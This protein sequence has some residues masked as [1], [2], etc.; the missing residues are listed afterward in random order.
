MIG[1]T[2]LNRYHLEA[3]LGRGGMG[4]VYR[5]QDTLLNR[6]VAVKLLSA[7]GLG[8]EGHTRLLREAQAVAR[9]NHPNI[10]LLYDAGE[11]AIGESTTVVPFI[12]MEL[13]SGQTL[14]RPS[15]L[16]VVELIPLA[17]QICAALD[18]AH[19][20][21]VI[22]RDLKPENM[23]LTAEGQVKLMDFGLARTNGATR[24]TTEGT[25]MGT[26]NY[27]APELL[28]GQEATPQSD[29]YA[30]GVILYQ[31]V[32]GRPPF[33]GD[34]LLAVLSQHLHA[35]VTPPSTYQ[36][37]VPPMLD[38]LIVQL[39]S[40]EPGD[41]PASVATVQQKLERIGQAN[42]ATLTITAEEA[43][44]L[45]YLV[46][47]RMVGRAKEFAEV[48]AAW[49]QAAAGETHV[50]LIT[51]EPG[52]GKSRLVREL[53]TLAG[54]NNGATTLTGE[55][56]AE[57]DAPYAP[58]GQ[59]VRAVFTQPKLTRALAL[60]TT[61]L[62]DLITLVPELRAHY[63]D[64]PPNPPSPEPRADQQRLF[65]S[66]V[67]L[68]T[69]LTSHAPLLIVLDDAHWADSGSLALLRHLARRGRTLAFP[70]LLAFTYRDAE[71]ADSDALT[72]VLLDLNRERLSTRLKLNRLDRPQT[73]ELLAALFSE[74]ISPEFLES[75]Y[76]ETEG[77]PFFV[78]EVCRSLIEEGKLYRENGRWQRPAMSELAVPP[79]IRLAIEAR[80]AKL[81]AAT[82][83]MLRLAAILGREFD[84]ATLAAASDQPEDSLIDAL[85]NA[86]KAQLVGEIKRK[87]GRNTTFAFVHALIPTTLRDMMNTLRRQ[88]LHRKVFA[89]VERLHADD[90]ERLAY[91]ATQAGDEARALHYYRQ[92]GD[93]AL[94]AF[95]NRE[96]EAHYRDALELG[97]S[98]EEQATLLAKLA[99][100]LMNLSRAGDSIPVRRQAIE[101]YRELGDYNQVARL[102]ALSARCAWLDGDTPAGLTICQEGMAVVD[103]RADGVPLAILL[104]ETARAQYFNGVRGEEALALCRQALAIGEAAGDPFVQ[105]ECLS[106]LGVL[107]T[108]VNESIASLTRAV[109]FA[110]SSGSIFAA[111][112]ARNNLANML[113]LNGDLVGCQEHLLR[114]AEQARQLGAV[115]N[116]LYYL[117][118]AAFGYSSF[119]ELDKVEAMLPTLYD[120]LAALPNPG[121]A[122]VNLKALE[123]RLLSRR[124]EWEQAIEDTRRLQAELRQ[125][126]QLHGLAL[127]C[128]YLGSLLLELGRLEEAETALQEAMAISEWGPTDPLQ[129]GY[130]LSAVYA[131]QGRPV[132]AHRLLNEAQ[133]KAG[134]QLAV[135]HQMQL[136]QAKARVALAEKRFDEAEAAFRQVMT[137]LEQMG[138]RWD[139]AQTC[140]EAAEL[141]LERAGQGDWE[142]AAS[143]LSRA[144]TLFATINVPRYT[145][146]AQ[147]RLNSLTT[148]A[149]EPTG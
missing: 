30:L 11:T 64:V 94:A 100:T 23:I 3:E 93:R 57:R 16:P 107:Q 86:E 111:T 102:Y 28:Q 96:A 103:G 113:R 32:A 39:L 128:T 26:F 60:P 18:H 109:Q 127:A 88:R 36:P 99:E 38:A 84:F 73:Q 21:Q 132:E 85:E 137:L 89:A 71:L 80:L 149:K 19:R 22:H 29:L 50:L 24:L 10:V 141:H 136:A 31:L 34:S 123:S 76:T 97:G 2:L 53:T 104:H 115:A 62:A 1:T 33:D 98:N 82:Q 125:R 4:V 91:H 14:R 146:L 77:N 9:L 5:A 43:S 47:G 66:V 17:L 108:D 133:E 46:R 45:D 20:H 118:G 49:R 63:P 75:I 106:T 52:I 105:A 48:K 42:T 114:A 148:A 51:G 92:A 25:L 67:A 145:A 119:G 7:T 55:C 12:V 81:S 6:P 54:L 69:Q 87:N 37:S 72:A 70:I 65:E 74:E 143:L 58:I 8:T 90:Y 68:C 130:F 15:P 120:L 44:P 131:R 147:E 112:R 139:L 78:E 129:A 27:M 95:A 144:A 122:A 138:M 40:K 126:G 59:M 140:R 41:R 124:G 13:V 35:P 121:P 79:S 83:D 110:E 56:Y 116:E 117:T 135:M 101:R 61:N 134:S 142:H